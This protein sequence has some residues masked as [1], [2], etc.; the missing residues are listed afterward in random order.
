MT[1]SAKQDALDAIKAL[2]EDTDIEEIMYRLFVLEKIR[3]G[4]A[5]A[6]A[7]RLTTLADLEREMTEW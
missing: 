5:D 3:K 4:R 7:G 1:R 6:E 2:P